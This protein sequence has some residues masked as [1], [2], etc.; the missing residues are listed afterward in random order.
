[1]DKRTQTEF[2]C[3]LTICCCCCCC[4][5]IFHFLAVCLFL[6]AK[7]LCINNLPRV[8]IFECMRRMRML[9]IVCMSTVFVRIRLIQYIVQWFGTL[10]HLLTDDCEYYAKHSTCNAGHHRCRRCLC[11]R[12]RHSGKEKHLLVL[13][14]WIFN[15]WF[16]RAFSVLPCTKKHGRSTPHCWCKFNFSSGTTILRCGCRPNIL[17]NSFMAGANGKNVR[18]CIKNF[19]L[20]NWRGEIINNGHAERWKHPDGVGR[21]SS[22]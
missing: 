5:C 22:R 2:Q 16:C 13:N 9:R 12:I 3:M 10:F 7:L 6:G 15:W 14:Y 21:A 8:N 18:N 4:S 1:M 17:C 20:A 19:L 11:I